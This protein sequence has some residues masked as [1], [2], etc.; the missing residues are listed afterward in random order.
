MEPYQ[1]AD[2]FQRLE[3][4][5][6]LWRR[7]TAITLALS[8]L[9]LAM[10]WLRWTPQELRIVS[11]DGKRQAVISAE[12]I[13]F[14]PRPDLEPREESWW[15]ASL[16]HGSLELSDAGVSAKIDLRR[17]VADLPGDASLRLAVGNGKA[18]NIDLFQNRLDFLGPHDGRFTVDL[19]DGKSLLMMSPDASEG[20]MMGI[21][22]KQD[23]AYMN[24][25]APN[26]SSFR[27]MLNKELAVMDLLGSKGESGRFGV[28]SDKVR[29]DISD[30]G[31]GYRSV[32][33]SPT[34]DKK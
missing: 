22:K 32:W 6:Q 4:Q 11:R 10:I 15:R 25:R 30:C 7:I 9:G 26:K 12:Q 2:R 17:G 33:T 14:D 27:V 34:C 16:G 20:L 24:L 31:Y 1:I 19:E 5:V 21:D 3:A 18:F 8:V 23:Y 13:R 28:S 29:L